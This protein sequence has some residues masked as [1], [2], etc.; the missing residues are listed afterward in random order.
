MALHSFVGASWRS[1]DV[2][3]KILVF[4]GQGSQYA[5][6]AKDW[7]DNFTQAKLAFEEA[8]DASG[9]DLRK[10]CFGE[11]E[12]DLAS[13]QVTQPALLTSSMA[14][15]R[16]LQ[17]MT[18]EFK[19]DENTLLAGHS[20][21]EYTAL[22]AA[23][24][25]SLHDAARLVKQ[26]G[27]FMMAACEKGMGG[28]TALVFKPK[29]PDTSKGAKKLCQQASQT[30]G[31]FCQIANINTPEQI[32]ISGHVEALDQVDVLVKE[33]D[34]GVRKV[35]RLNV[36]GP[37]HSALMEKAA[38]QLSS[39][40]EK[41]E[42]RSRAHTHYIANVD[43]AIHNVSESVQGLRERLVAQVTGSVLW[44]NS[45]QQALA[46]GATASFEIGPNA[47]LSGM[48]KR[49]EF[50]GQGFHVQNIDRLDKYRE[51]F[52]HEGN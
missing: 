19:V 24:V 18:D 20:L 12:S 15:Y 51:E 52:K 6:M 36:S 13:T 26:R 22:V 28:M 11:N 23:E 1:V 32:V 50:Q 44:V 34:F 30:S 40:L 7:Y 8:S 21:G 47:V 10:L 29:S 9:L 17:S 45:M 49:I 37:F 39:A 33:A 31:K 46:W 38:K 43:A 2:A 25:I 14:I 4:P 3:K 41:V 35:V 16:S 27:E 42:M 5:G 48:N